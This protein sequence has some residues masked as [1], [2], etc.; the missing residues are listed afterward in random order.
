MIRV[1]IVEDSPVVRD[2]LRYLLDSDP[3]VQVAGTAQ[4]GA[5][6]VAFVD[7]QEVDVIMMDIHMPRMD[8]FEATRRIMETHP[9]PIVIVSASWDPSEVDK[10]FRAMEAGAVTA[11]VK[12]VGIGH[13]QAEEEARKII[14]TVKLM[15][16]VKVV[17]RWPQRRAA[18]PVPKPLS[19][20]RSPLS[21]QAEIVAIGASTGGPPALQTVLT[22]LGKG[23]PAPILI[24]Q[25]I[26]PGFLPGMAD[27]LGE[28]T[29]TPTQ[30]AAR[31]ERP[32]AG[33]AY[34]APD[35]YHMGVDGG[36]RIALDASAPENGLR[37]AVSYLFRSV[38]DVFG[39]H[40]VGVL[41]TGMGKDG[42]EALKQM[43]D[44]GAVTIA[45][46]RESCVIYGMPGEA[47]RLGAAAHVLPLDRIAPRLLEIVGRP[48]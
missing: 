41:L 33:R 2:Y 45:Q 8:G 11:L 38:T 30:I 23:F 47:V 37:P 5:E 19:G 21:A 31:G 40:A 12:P 25:H 3:D 6:A 42:A 44:R 17:K 29:G 32:I 16:E 36:G 48:G 15:S 46:D 43:K 4:D 1:L 13:P 27:W 9:V 28:S 39:P 34:L 14:R 26:A 7:W 18:A 20:V 22:G 10:T 24:V 35:G